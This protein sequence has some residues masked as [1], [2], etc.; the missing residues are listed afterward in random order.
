MWLS[1]VAASA[2]CLSMQRPILNELPRSE[3]PYAKMLL[4]RTAFAANLGGMT[5]PIASPQN[6]VAFTALKGSVSFAGWM[7]VT[8]PT[9]ALILVVVAFTLPAQQAEEAHSAASPRRTPTRLP[10]KVTN[11]RQE[12][13]PWSFEQIIVLITL[14]ITA[15]FWLIGP[16]MHPVVGNPAL[17]S[18]FPLVVF[19]GQGLLTKQDFVNLPWDVICLLIGGS[20]LGFAVSKSGLLELITGTIRAFL[21]AYSLG[22]WAAIA[23]LVPVLWVMSAAV[24]SA[25]AATVLIPFMQ[26]L[27]KAADAEAAYVFSA[28]MSISGSMALPVSSFPNM[29]AAS[30]IDPLTSSPYLEAKDFLRPG[31]SMGFLVGVVVIFLVYPFSSAI[32]HF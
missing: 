24:P 14:V 32:S 23:V 30:C 13:E 10:P 19:Y 25:A 2:L 27:G 11:I 1:N 6:V 16:Q 4:L 12:P 21:A 28:V 7:L 17:L 29:G 18:V 15:I 26:A 5:T 31:A 3:R 22:H 8:V 9:T 20:C